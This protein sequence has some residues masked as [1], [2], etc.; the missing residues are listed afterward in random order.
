[1]FF[2]RIINF[3]KVL[4]YKL[5]GKVY[6][7]SKGLSISPDCSGIVFLDDSSEKQGKGQLIMP[8]SLAPNEF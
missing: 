1:V 7:N 5:F 8:K 6:K 3:D 4:K 2:K